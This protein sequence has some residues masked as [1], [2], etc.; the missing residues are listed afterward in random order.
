MKTLSNDTLTEKPRIYVASLADYNVGNLHGR[1]IDATQ[2]ADAI[3]REIAEMLAA[4][5]EP[6]AEEYAIHDY[7]NFRGLRLA[8]FEDIDRVAEVA[9][10]IAEHGPVFAKLVEH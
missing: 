2:G 10:L 3:R 9:I 5:P 6:D 1:W 8:E 4:S 7:D